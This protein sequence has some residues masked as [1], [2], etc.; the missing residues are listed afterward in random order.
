MQLIYIK[1]GGGK[2]QI[3]ERFLSSCEISFTFAAAKQTKRDYVNKKDGKISCSQS[4]LVFV[5][6]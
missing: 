2:V 5:C 6:P 3:R 4:G 1:K